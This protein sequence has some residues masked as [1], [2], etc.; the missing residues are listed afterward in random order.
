[1]N[2]KI[3]E[4]KRRWEINR[5]DP[6]RVS[7]LVHELGVSPSVAAVYLSRGI[8][9]TSKFEEFSN[10][11]QVLYD[12]YLLPDMYAAVDRI[13]QA[14][15]ERE[16]ILIHGDAD[17][18]GICSSV[19]VNYFLQ[20]L[21]GCEPFCHVPNRLDEGFGLSVASVER[22]KLSGVSLIITTDCGTEAYHAADRAQQLGT[23]LIITDHHEVKDRG[24]PNCVACINP[25]RNTSLY[26]FRDLA[27]VGVAYK[28][29]EALAE[30]FADASAY[31]VLQANGLPLLVLGTIA[32]CVPLLGENRSLVMEGLKDLDDNGMLWELKK[33]ARVKT[34]DTETVGYTFA[35]MIN[36]CCRLGCPEWALRLL[37]E[38][39]PKMERVYAHRLK[40]LNDERKAVQLE[41]EEQVFHSLP[42]DASHHKFLLAS[43]ENWH[44]GL[45]G[46]AANRLV[47]EYGKPSFVVGAD[48]PNDSMARGS[49]RSVPGTNILEALESCDDLLTKFGGHAGAAGFQLPNANVERLEQRLFN[50]FDGI[51][52]D[53]LGDNPL[54]IDAEMPLDQITMR[55]YEQIEKLSPFG[56]GNERPVLATNNLVV[57]NAATFGKDSR[58]LRLVFTDPNRAK[59][60]PAV[61]WNAGDQIGHLAPGSTVAVAH[62]LIVDN[63]RAKPTLMMNILDVRPASKQDG[64]I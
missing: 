11:S 12:P 20:C 39:D 6:I 31:E 29:L 18:D 34:I 15:K 49:C 43:G 41:L 47:S 24:I 58:H 27:G 14:Y 35:P 7:T 9:S 55:V 10:G 64:G 25:K 33:A 8:D 1:M 13:V 63:Y 40:E 32:D 56:H 59:C 53:D 48:C 38:T 30:R 16:T 26:P 21:I 3:I 45:I 23:D 4:H 60:T 19:L 22:A 46:L 37:L 61:F 42:D 51:D 5:P 50:Y 52:Y 54:R 57:A 28:F 2:R 44:P 17:C 62:S 36:S